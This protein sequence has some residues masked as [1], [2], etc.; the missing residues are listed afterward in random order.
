V[1]AA[2][3]KAIEEGQQIAI[4]NYSNYLSPHLT[5]DVGDFNT[6]DDRRFFVCGKSEFFV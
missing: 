3:A 2:A 5:D 4:V 1:A 6:V